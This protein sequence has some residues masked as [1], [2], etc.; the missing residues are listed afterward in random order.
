MERQQRRKVGDVGLTSQVL[1]TVVQGKRNAG[2]RDGNVV[3]KATHAQ[4][5]STSKCAQL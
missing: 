3:S 2:G 5:H 1:T 4:T